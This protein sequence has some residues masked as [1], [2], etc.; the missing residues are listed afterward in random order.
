[1]TQKI[2]I[3]A[4]HGGFGLSEAALERY[5]QLSG[6]ELPFYHW[7]ISRDCSH[8]VQVVEELG[9]SADTRYANLKVVEIPDDVEWTIHDYDGMEWVAEAHRTWS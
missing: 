2:V 1:M 9:E 3:N 4:N 6:L 5:A 7:Q 8:L